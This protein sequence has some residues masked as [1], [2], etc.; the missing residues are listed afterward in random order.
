M[1]TAS[2]AVFWQEKWE[3]GETGFHE[4]QANPL[5]TRHIAALDL[6]AGAQIFVPLCGMSQDMVWL[7]GQGY[8]VTGCELSDVAVRRFFS[9]LGLTP[10]IVQA[11][12][13][14]RFFAG[15]ISILEGNIFDLTPGLLGPMDAIYDRAALI[16]FPEDLRRAYVAHLLSL[17]GPVPELLVT[18]DYDQSCLKGPPFSVSEASLRSYYGKAYTLTLLESRAVEG[19]L[20]GRCPASENVWRLSPLLPSS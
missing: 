14:R 20:K 13:L 7:A 16:A 2:N 17:T 19:G 6:L 18:L 4:P 8:H 3:R 15:S 12:P 5:L 10:A 1:D 9:D 11:G